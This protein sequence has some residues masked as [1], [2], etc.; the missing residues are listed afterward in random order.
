MCVIYVHS[1]ANVVSLMQ[2]SEKYRVARVVCLLHMF[3]MYGRKCGQ[4]A[5]DVL[6][7]VQYRQKKLRQQP[8]FCPFLT[9]RPEKTR[10]D[11][12]HL[13]ADLCSVVH[14]VL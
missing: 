6:N 10:A 11:I 4:P 5:E 8:N 7:T 2:L 9:E 12:K 13:F 14:L 3:A 1:V